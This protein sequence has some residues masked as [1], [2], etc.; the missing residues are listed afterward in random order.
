M[1]HS[2][3]HQNLIGSW[4][5]KVGGNRVIT[6]TF[7]PDGRVQFIGEQGKWEISN[8][9]NND[10]HATLNM[11]FIRGEERKTF[12]ATNSF[13]LSKDNNELIIQSERG[14]LFLQRHN[15][16][17]SPTISSPLEHTKQFL[18]STKES[19]GPISPLPKPLLYIYNTLTAE[20]G[21]NAQEYNDDYHGIH[22][23]TPP[24]HQYVVKDHVVNIKSPKSPTAII[25]RMH[26]PHPEH[27]IR[28][29][30]RA[31][32]SEGK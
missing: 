29:R 19:I 20:M 28:A 12:I 26:R 15:D 30:Y 1:M 23:L 4:Q 31:G 11:L 25:A 8:W 9:N 18:E 14:T 6:A 22:F 13:A 17:P 7:S 21:Q 2:R 24:N 16:T 3:L 27:V 5:G 10:L 32:Y